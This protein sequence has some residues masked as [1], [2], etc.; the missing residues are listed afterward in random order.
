[1]KKSIKENIEKQIKLFKVDDYIISIG[2]I[3]SLYKSGGIIIDSD[4]Q[5]KFGWSKKQKSKFIESLFFG[6][7]IPPILIYQSNA[8][9]WK[10]INMSQRLFTI[11]EFFGVLRK[12]NNKLA[13]PLTLSKTKII[14]ELRGLRFKNFGNDVDFLPTSLRLKLKRFK[15]KIRILSEN[16]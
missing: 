13:K 5:Q 4:F 16:E 10:V 8:G 9:E 3:V 15:L 7:S 2:E 14:P 11:L 12:R 6:V 1:M